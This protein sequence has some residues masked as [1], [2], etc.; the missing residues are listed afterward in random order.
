MGLSQRQH[1]CEN[2]SQFDFAN[3]ALQCV[4]SEAD[5]H[6]TSE[7]SKQIAVLIFFCFMIQEAIRICSELSWQGPISQAPIRS[8]QGTSTF[9]GRSSSIGT[10][11]K[12][13]STFSSQAAS[14]R[15]PF[16]LADS[17]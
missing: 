7:S 11:V 8:K 14:Q 1:L 12:S 6:S 10:R 2:M 3:L 15:E 17:N 9:H 16:R 4:V 13:I 5:V